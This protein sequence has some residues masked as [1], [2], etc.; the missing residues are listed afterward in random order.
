MSTLKW[1]VWNTEVYP[2]VLKKIS[3]LQVNVKQQSYVLPAQHQAL[4]TISFQEFQATGQI[5]L[6][7]TWDQLGIKF[8]TGENAAVTTRSMGVLIS[9]FASPNIGKIAFKIQP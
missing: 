2:F 7:G 9:V 5:L 8:I 6:S 1:E 3:L 4:L